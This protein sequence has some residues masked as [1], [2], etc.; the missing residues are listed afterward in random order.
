[1]KWM[2]QPQ[3]M[4]FIVSLLGFS[5]GLPLALS[6]ATLQFWYNTTGISFM[7]L[8]LVNI[9]GLPYTFKFLWAPFMDRY[10]WPRLGRRRGWMLFTQALLVLSLFLM[11]FTSPASSPYVLGALAVFV[12][13]FSASQDVAVDA[14]RTDSLTDANLGMGNALYTAGYRVAMLISGGLALILAG[15]FG[16]QSTYML[17][18]ALMCI[19]IVA[20]LFGREPSEKLAPA[21]T[22]LRNAV[23]MPFKAFLERPAAYLILAFILLYKLGDAFTFSLL[24]PFLSRKLGLS[25]QELGVIYKTVGLLATLFGVFLGGSLLRFLGMYRSLMLF[26]LLQG[27]SCL[28]FMV[29]LHSGRSYPLLFCTVALENVTS[30]M[31]TIAF[32]SFLM[33]LCD[34]RYTATQFALLSSFSAIGRVYVGPIAGYIADHYGWNNYFIIGFLLSLPGLILLYWM[35]RSREEGLD[36]F[37]YP[38]SST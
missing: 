28:F 11:G 3:K 1:M 13:F 33:K 19:G 36:S 9:I 23:V 30:G 4:L 25:L 20:T 6:G 34:H 2:M 31:G 26:G 16:F 22:S 8:G 32:I 14:Y 5:S 24:G 15:Q 35:H 27:I 12:A 10:V 7:A 38:A 17:M 37:S 29:L 21:P 18:A